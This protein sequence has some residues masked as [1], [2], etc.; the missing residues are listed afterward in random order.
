MQFGHEP[1]AT[2]SRRPPYKSYEVIIYDVIAGHE[3]AYVNNSSQN[4]AT[5]VGEV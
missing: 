5:A 1:S 4:R 2:A 3:N